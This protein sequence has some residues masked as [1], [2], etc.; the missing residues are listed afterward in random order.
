MTG[1]RTTCGGIIRPRPK[2]AS[3]S[4]FVRGPRSE[5]QKLRAEASGMTSPTV[6][7][8][9]SVELNKP[10]CTRLSGRV[11]ALM[12][13]SKVKGMGSPSGFSRICAWVL[14]AF[15]RAMPIGNTNAKV[16][17][18]PTAIQNTVRERASRFA[19]CRRG[20]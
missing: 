17:N 5:I 8:V 4:P 7:T 14:N 11:H 18:Q 19:D 2:T 9:T 20:A 1:C 6:I 10:S 16:T 13:L 15:D 3:S 12:M